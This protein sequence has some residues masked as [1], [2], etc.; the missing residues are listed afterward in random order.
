M[1][2]GSIFE[3]VSGEQQHHSGHTPSERAHPDTR[4]SPGN[5][6]LEQLDVDRGLGKLERICG[7]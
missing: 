6:P 3:P 4:P 2:V 7:N 5:P 1:P